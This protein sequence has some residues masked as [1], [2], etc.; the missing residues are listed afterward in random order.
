MERK[1]EC[2]ICKR[3]VR[4]ILSDSFDGSIEQHNIT[5]IPFLIRCPMSETPVTENR[6]DIKSLKQG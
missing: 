2:P 5:I 3:Q 4:I 1:I 6:F